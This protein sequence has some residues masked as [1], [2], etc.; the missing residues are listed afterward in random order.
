[1][2]VQMH[3][4]GICPNTDSNDSPARTAHMDCK[5]G[6]NL[7]MIRNRGLCEMLDMKAAIYGSR[8]ESALSNKGRYA[9]MEGR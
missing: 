9:F 6:Q 8:K 3:Y 5:D 1:M 4:H 7:G 2:I